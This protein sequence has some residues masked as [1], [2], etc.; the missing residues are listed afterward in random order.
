MAQDARGVHGGGGH[1][2]YDEGVS[3]DSS[4][5]PSGSSAETRSGKGSQAS[6]EMNWL[7][8]KF[9]DFGDDE[10]EPRVQ[11]YD[12]VVAH[13]LG[14]LEQAGTAVDLFLSA[15]DDE[16][17][18]SRQEFLA[19]LNS[20]AGRCLIDPDESDHCRSDY[21]RQSTLLLQAILAADKVPGT[22]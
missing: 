16:G 10:A 6:S 13:Q 2:R 19:E 1:R 17:Y 15:I 9:W 5:V 3:R 7:L 11:T 21:A 8:R 12:V 14:D 4:P 18:S 20:T 22:D